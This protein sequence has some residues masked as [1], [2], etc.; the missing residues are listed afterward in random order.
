MGMATTTTTERLSE[1]CLA[2]MRAACEI[3]GPD[4]EHVRTGS[5]FVFRK[6]DVLIRVER[7][8]ID[9]DVV[10][11]HGVAAAR[12]C[13]G[14]VGAPRLIAPVTTA[15]DA[16]V[17]SLWGWVEHSEEPCDV[18]VLG[19]TLAS[20]HLSPTSGLAPFNPLRYTRERLHASRQLVTPGEWR[21]LE[22]A[23]TRG[24][25]LVTSVPRADHLVHGDF[26]PSNVLDAPSGPVVIDFEYVGA[27]N[28]GWDL[29]KIAH[30]A[31]RFNG[32]SD[33][34]HVAYLDAYWA[35]GGPGNLDHLDRML[36]V[37]DVRSALWTVCSRR[38][39]SWFMEESCIRLETL[40]HPDSA[41]KWTAL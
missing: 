31:C 38:F 25:H 17:I 32:Q 24:E 35:A 10:R 37:I 20:V 11:S 18:G 27:G 5:A 34:N 29:A 22:S 6:N 19:A 15:S 9:P 4:I 39:S 21:L 16:R 2:A 40:R 30:R 13:E 23:L 28:P 8:G 33:A 12:L 1:E 3:V 7:H 36:P 26:N 41:T 14:G